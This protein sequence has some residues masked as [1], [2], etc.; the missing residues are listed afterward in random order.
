[1][2]K[3]SQTPETDSSQPVCST[4]L[5]PALLSLLCSLFFF[6]FPLPAF[7]LFTRDLCRNKSNC[8]DTSAVL[9]WKSRTKG[10]KN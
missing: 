1:M 6:I 8:A 3:K 5:L 4:F 2:P 10:N 9:V 7:S